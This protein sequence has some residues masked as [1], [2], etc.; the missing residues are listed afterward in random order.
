MSNSG[1]KLTIGSFAFLLS[2]GCSS[3]KKFGVLVNILRLTPK[4]RVQIKC[5]S[6][7]EAIRV[8]S[9]ADVESLR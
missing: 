7:P 6:C 4:S 2:A 3:V 8:I 9:C 5:I 1:R